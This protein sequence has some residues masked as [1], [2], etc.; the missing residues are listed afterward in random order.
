MQRGSKAIK[1]ILVT[2]GIAFMSLPIAAEVPPAK[3]V[4]NPSKAVVAKPAH[5]PVA[6][7][8]SATPA[9]KKTTVSKPASKAKNPIAQ[10]A[11]PRVAT[12]T[13]SAQ[14]IDKLRQSLSAAESGRWDEAYRLAAQAPEPFRDIIAWME[15]NNAPSNRSFSDIIT[16]ASAHSDW[17]SKERLIKAAEQ[18][19]QPYDEAMRAWFEINPPITA[20]GALRWIEMLQNN[21]QSDAARSIASEAWINRA[22]SDDDEK[23]FLAKFSGLLTPKD[24]AGR[25]DRLAWEGEAAGIQRM[26]GLADP[27]AIKIAEIRLKFQQN[28][29]DANSAAN[30]LDATAQADPGLIYERVR[31]LRRKNAYAEAEA[32]LLSF[33]GI[34]Q[35]PEAWWVERII[36]ARHALE[37]NRSDAAYAL[38]AP[39]GLKSGTEFADA[40]FFAGWVALRRLNKPQDALRH[41]S[42]L[43]KGVSTPISLARGNFWQGRAYEAMG[44]KAEALNY[45]EIAA[46]NTTTFYGQLAAQRLGKPLQINA[47]GT[48]QPVTQSDF[49]DRSV[50]KATALLLEIGADKQSSVF[51]THLLRT[52]DKPEESATLAKL[53]ANL[54][55]PDLAIRAAKLAER[56]GYILLTESYPTVD[57]K[58]ISVDA[59]P[60]LV[61]ALIRQESAFDVDIVSRAG[62]LG[63]MQLMPA[64]AKLVAKDHK[65]PFDLPRLTRDGDY[66]VSLGSAHISDLVNEYGGSY[67]MAT[68]AYNAGSHRVKRW[69]QTFG[70]PRLPDTDPIDWIESIT[71]SETR[72]Y[73]QRVL[74]TLSF[75]RARLAVNGVQ[76]QIAIGYDLTRGGSNDARPLPDDT[77]E[78]ADVPSGAPP[79]IAE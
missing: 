23:E 67:I 28:D 74:E 41:F 16:Y 22:F 63:L 66:N 58:P 15:I 47:A 19:L 21:G 69:V 54:S 1:F 64:T 79:A 76:Q 25:L 6:K 49:S 55:R 11:P 60:A 7:P 65:L 4:K 59:D 77:P 36:L 62:A 71:F 10:K 37:E 72:N 73:V 46:K 24:H 27:T 12:P 48:L 40:E 17:P 68:A 50:V 52:F 3:S 70:D 33:S 34:M 39:H 29:P 13:L 5:N 2:V 45:Y 78:I 51:F 57:T 75:Y 30:Q 9:K 42:A 35:K 44:Q 18:S 8:V 26:R 14:Q 38:V 20:H 56:G 31:W 32:L 53:A 61:H 43:S